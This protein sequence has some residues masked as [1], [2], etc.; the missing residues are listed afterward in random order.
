LNGNE[1][2]VHEMKINVIDG[3]TVDIE[4]GVFPGYPGTEPKAREIITRSHKM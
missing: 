1:N 3:R 2:A 4:N